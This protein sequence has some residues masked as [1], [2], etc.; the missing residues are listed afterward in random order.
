M[1]SEKKKLKNLFGEIDL[2]W[3]K[4]ILFSILAGVYTAIMTLVPILKI[5]SFHDITVSFE[6]WVLFG[7]IIIMNSKSA[8]D[9]A[10]KCFV[11]FLISQPLVYLIQVPFSNEGLEI[12]RYYGYWFVW[13]LAT[14]PMGFIG[15]YMKKDKWWGLLI[16]TP[17]I[18]L[19]GMHYYTYLRETIYNFPY[20]LLTSIFCCATILIYSICIFKNKKIKTFAII[21]ATLIILTATSMAFMNKKIYSTILL[22][23]ESNDEG[24]TFDE[25][26]AVYLEDDLGKV[27]IEYESGAETYVIKADFEKAGDTMLI[28]EDENNNKIYFK[29]NVRSDTFD[30]KLQET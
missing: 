1:Q 15:Y 29:L 8:K 7:I 22:V 12:F 2:D 14:L 5:T 11:F 24:V 17:I 21:V 28:L 13:T 23:S 16:I 26:D 4:L 19:L 30:I 18:L 6:V 20:H 27:Y 10:L 3:K 9:S 25:D